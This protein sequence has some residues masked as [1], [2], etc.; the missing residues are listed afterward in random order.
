M[1]SVSRTP[2]PCHDPCAQAARRWLP[3]LEI[4]GKVVEALK[5]LKAL[6]IPMAI[7]SNGTPGMLDIA[8]KSAGMTAVP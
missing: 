7:L 8:V 4:S 3:P 6:G 2:V 1:V 5:E